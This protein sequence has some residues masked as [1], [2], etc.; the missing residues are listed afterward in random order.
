MG[1]ISTLTPTQKRSIRRY[2]DDGKGPSDIYF[3]TGI[4]LGKVSYYLKSLEGNPHR[5]KTNGNGEIYRR[6]KPAAE[7][8]P[9]R[10]QPT[11]EVGNALANPPL[12]MGELTDAIMASTDRRMEKEAA[13]Q[14]AQH[15]LNFFGYSDRIIDNILEP[16]DRDLLYM[17]EDAGIATT[18]REETT[19]Y[20]GRE[21]RIHYWM[22][23]PYRIAEILAPLK[24]AG[25]V[26]EPGDVYNEVPNEIW[27]THGAG[28][29]EGVHV[30]NGLVATQAGSRGSGSLPT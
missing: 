22:F 3:Y 7:P 28:Q 23:R 11:K 9:V 4:P 14:I 8:A 24:A 20:D 6:D 13:G 16:E 5:K 26:K 12:L 21:W 25:A 18:K 27:R 1:R 29:V 19:L 30:T 2:R 17:L 10:P 15:V